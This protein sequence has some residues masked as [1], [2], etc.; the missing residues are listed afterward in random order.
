MYEPASDGHRTIQLEQP[1]GCIVPT[2]D[3]NILL[4]ALEVRLHAQPGYWCR[5]PAL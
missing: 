1:I 4:A 3:P 2:S 5:L